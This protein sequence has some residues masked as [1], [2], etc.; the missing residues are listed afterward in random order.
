MALYAKLL[1]T[2]QQLAD[3]GA[4]PLEAQER[5]IIDDL[6]TK[7]MWVCWPMHSEWERDKGGRC[8]YR[9]IALVW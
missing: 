8:T 4:L 7:V 6:V 2:A 9:A 5:A 1:V 3:F